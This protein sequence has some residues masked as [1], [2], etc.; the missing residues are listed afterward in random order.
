MQTG[1][2]SSVTAKRLKTT[3]VGAGKRD[4]ILILSLRNQSF[5]YIKINL[6][7]KARVYSCSLP[8]CF[9]YEEVNEKKVVPEFSGDVIVVHTRWFS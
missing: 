6:F 5:L 4:F 7:V 9:N 3:E 2:S 1:H 8:G